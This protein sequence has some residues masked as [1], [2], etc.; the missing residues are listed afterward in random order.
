VECGAQPHRRSGRRRPR[1]AR[2]QLPARQQPGAGQ[3]RPQLRRPVASVRRLPDD[4][5][6]AYSDALGD[7]CDADDD[8]DGI[9]DTAETAGPPCASASAATNPLLA[10][11]D[12][13]RRLD[14]A[15][16]LLNK[17]PVNGAEL[18]P[19][20]LPDADND[21]LPAALDPDDATPDIDGDGMK[22][23]LEFRHY[24]TSIFN[25]DTDGDAC[26]DALEVASI[27]A[28]N[29]INSG[30]QLL[31]AL[32]MNRTGAPPPLV[33]IDMNKDGAINSAEQLF[34]AIQ[35]VAGT[36]CA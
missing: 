4:A 7:A 14:L 12:G 5:T 31:L 20:I 10:D 1:R 29:A 33:N 24:N 17:D 8:N 32:E 19:P 26:P 9:P 25:T 3:Q 2:R 36:A 34:L 6:V 18:W 21:Q 15:E 35:L 13:D 23:G 22:D 27:N 28:D 11:T 16:C 30:D